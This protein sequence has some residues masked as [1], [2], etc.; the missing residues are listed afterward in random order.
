MTSKK[1]R[2]LAKIGAPPG[3]LVH[4]GRPRDHKVNI[5]VYDYS[6]THCDV[7]SVDTI[8]ESLER[9]QSD[10]NT[11]IN[12]DGL[13]EVDTI[14][15]VGEVFNLNPLVLEDILNTEQRPKFEN[16]GDF[17][18][19]VTKMVS[20]HE[21]KDNHD[22]EHLCIVLGRNFVLTFQEIEG[23]VLDPVRKRLEME[24]SRI[25]NRPGDY[26]TY[27]ILDT[28]VDNYLPSVE[29]SRE[30]IEELEER[31]INAEEL[32]ITDELQ[33][34]TRELIELRRI[35]WPMREVIST[36]RQFETN[37]IREDTDPF[38]RDIQDH[39]NHFADILESNH[40]LLGGLRDMH[41][42]NINNKMNEVMKMLTIIATIF[43]P[44]T[45]LA[46]VYGMNF[47][48]MPELNWPWAY[49]VVLVL[50][51]AVAIGMFIYF[52]RKKWL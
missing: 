39:L 30:R 14:R 29:R 50:M 25:R 12:I 36:M 44:L 8:E 52:K 26:L 19:I 2:L 22:V 4:I 33:C 7:F 45:F 41:A 27:V 32:N 10:S 11:W 9:A 18:F 49:P 24:T 13:H 47:H 21:D 43:I 38:L 51:L 48:F 40:D 37:L 35:V 3:T 6:L 16:H 20:Y 34:S 5:S 46:G 15:R 17:Y 1:D 28:I 23:D 42:T 31:L